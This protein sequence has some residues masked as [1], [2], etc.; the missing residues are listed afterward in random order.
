MLALKGSRHRTLGFADKQQSRYVLIDT[1]A[2]PEMLV[3]G[4]MKKLAFPVF[5]HRQVF[6]KKMTVQNPLSDQQ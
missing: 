6:I 5:L 3:Q 1:L 2:I 4:W